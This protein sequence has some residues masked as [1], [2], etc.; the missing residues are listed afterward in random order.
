MG[1]ERERESGVARRCRV[2]HRLAGERFCARLLH[3]YF[4]I[5]GSWRKPLVIF[6]GVVGQFDGFFEL[7]IVSADHQIGALGHNVVGID[8]VIFHNPLAAVVGAPET[9]TW[10]GDASSVAWRLGVTD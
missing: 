4:G 9:E 2:P 10:S 5:L 1:N 8:T 3:L 6:K 7:R